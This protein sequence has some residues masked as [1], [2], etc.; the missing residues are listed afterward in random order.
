MV[1]ARDSDFFGQGSADQAAAKALATAEKK[2]AAAEEDWL[3]L[4][5]KREELD[6]EY[7][8]AVLRIYLRGI[9]PLT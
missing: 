1:A 8:R 6:E 3:A 7:L 4:E 2:L 9:A 5:M